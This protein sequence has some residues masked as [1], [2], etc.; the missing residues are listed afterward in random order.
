MFNIIAFQWPPCT[1]SNRNAQRQ[2]ISPSF[3]EADLI[4]HRKLEI[5]LSSI[6]H[7]TSP[8]WPV[9]ANTVRVWAKRGTRETVSRSMSIIYS[10]PRRD[11][12]DWTWF[13]ARVHR[14]SRGWN[15]QCR[16]GR[17]RRVEWKIEGGRTRQDR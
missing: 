5:P 15:L 1:M 2:I 17:Q 7:R 12:Q 10:R 16:Y 4:R 13:A 9:Y 11:L 8:T 14:E 6:Y 3:T